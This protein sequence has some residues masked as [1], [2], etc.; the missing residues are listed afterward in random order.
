MKP[1]IAYGLKGTHYHYDMVEITSKDNFYYY[2]RE[3]NGSQTRGR[4]HDLAAEFE[5]KMDA[6][7]AI[8]DIQKAQAETA[9]PIAAAAKLTKEADFARRE[10][11]K[12]AIAKHKKG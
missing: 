12:A 2:G 9:G 4:L 1:A 8:I 10:A 5:N 11:V 6:R 7:A 3:E